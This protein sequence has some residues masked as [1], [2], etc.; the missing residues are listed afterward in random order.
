[1]RKRVILL[2]TVIM[3]STLTSQAGETVVNRGFT[4]TQ[5]AL[6]AAVAR[7]AAEDKKSSTEE[8][9]PKESATEEK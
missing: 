7:D 3:M 2:I 8:T 6:D 9:K 4:V 5:I 1:M